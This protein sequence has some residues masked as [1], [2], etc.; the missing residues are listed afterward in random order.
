MNAAFDILPVTLLTGFLGSGKSTVLADVLQGEHAQDTAVLVNEF[1][2]VGLDHLLIREVDARTVLL[3]NGCV[4]C[5]IRGELKEALAT[6]FSQRIRGEVPPFSRVIVETTGLAMPAPIIATLLADPAIRNHYTL[7]TVVTV[8]DAVN[9][10]EQQR[11]YP[12]WL[13]QVTAADHLLL[14]KSD[15]VEA[16]RVPA[17][18]DTLRMLNPAAPVSI[19]APDDHDALRTTLFTA[20]HA[21]TL[22]Q[23]I[24]STHKARLSAGYA[25]YAGSD[26]LAHRAALRAD[27]PA[28]AT[29]AI[30]AFCIEIAAPIDW[31]IFTIWFTLLLN[32]HG[33]KILRVKGVLSIA[34]ASKPVVLHGVRHL[35]HPV[36]HLDRWPDPRRDS[37]IVFI[38]EDIEQ[39]EIEASYRR[40][41]EHLEEQTQ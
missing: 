2:D 7:H 9:A 25:G 8:V 37:R 27:Q 36:L 6:L 29:P 33:D 35:V 28:N 23:R 13:A 20:G 34:G 32:R 17:L 31:Q 5:S 12:E 21:E 22:L 19:R 38:T 1:G 11:Q 14:T 41:C 15:L 26:R 40:F 4:C 16:D 39:A 10:F 30:K 24:G 3:D 18:F